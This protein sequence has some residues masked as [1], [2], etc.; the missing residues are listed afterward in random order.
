M[1]FSR[2]LVALVVPPA[3]LLAGA[4]PRVDPTITTND[5]RQSAGTLRNGVLTLGLEAT[6]GIW[7]PEGE[8]GAGLRVFAFRADRDAPQVPGPLIRV[9]AGT[10]LSIT[11]RNSLDR[12]LLVR[13]LHPHDG[14]RT[15]SLMLAAGEAR[16]VRFRASTPG[17]H[18]YWGRTGIGPTALGIGEDSQLLG[19]FVVDSPGVSLPDERILVITRWADTMDRQPSGEPRRTFV[20]NGLSW[21]HSER[22]TYR[23]GDSVRWRVLNLSVLPHPMHL[24]GF[25][26]NVDSRGDGGTDTVYAEAQRR[27]V[28]TE[29]LPAGT[30]MRTTWVPRRAGNWLFHCHLIAHISTELRLT[31]RPDAEGHAHGALAP[32]TH[33]TEG[34]VG[35][36]TGIHVLPRPGAAAQQEDEPRRRLRVFI[37]E[38]PGY[39][40]EEPGLGVVLQEGPREPAADSM[41]LPGSTIELLRGEPTEIVVRNRTREMV[42]IHW[43]GIELESYFDGVGDWSGDQMRMAPPIAPGDSFVVRM[44]PDRAGTFIYHTHMEE[45]NQINSGIYGPLIVRE[46]GEVPDPETDRILL[47]GWRGPGEDA[48]AGLNGDPEPDTLPM[49]VGATY[50]LRL[51][52]ITPSSPVRVTLLADS[53]VQQW[54]LFAKDG[55]TLPPQQARTVRAYQFIGPGETYDYEYTPAAPADLQLQMEVRRSGATLHVLQLPIHVVPEV[56]ER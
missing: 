13:G 39:F 41:R 51:I 54:R 19:A 15:D 7:Q 48:R 49:R 10:E 26:F 25:Y 16:E 14:Q 45:G 20:V 17:T 43:H 8:G 2:A 55:A 34:M 53:T 40:G 33:A 18:Y 42:T 11:V 4:R 27:L 12:P 37:N 38:R 3:L 1:T 56:P 47:V 28:V 9:P 5:N 22:L 29:F 6:V 46:P 52:N 44:T 32:G 31:P 24:H 50:R 23:V 21:P 35:L 36:V 30:T